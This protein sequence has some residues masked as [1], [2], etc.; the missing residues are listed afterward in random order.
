MCKYVSHV[1]YFDVIKL[2]EVIMRI[3]FIAVKYNGSFIP[4]VVMWQYAAF[5]K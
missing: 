4:C 5:A 1:I 3:K 2:T